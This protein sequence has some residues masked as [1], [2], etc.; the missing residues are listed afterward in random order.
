MS[1]LKS[2]KLAAAQPVR[3]NADPV[4]RT[5]NKVVEALAEQKTMAEAKIAGHHYAPTHLVWRKN[6][7]GE[8]VQMEKPKRIR[9]G[10]FNDAAGKT[11]FS[12]RYAGKPIEFAKDKNAIEVGDIKNLPDIIDQLIAAVQAGELDHQLA[13]AAEARGQQLRKAKAA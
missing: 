4:Q 10:W 8:R 12:L 5:R 11:F 2:L 1:H 7:A 9:V 6:E 13:S 3:V